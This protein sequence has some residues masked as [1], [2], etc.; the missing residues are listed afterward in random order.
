M[1]KTY[2]LEQLG[3]ANCAQKM[4]DEIE[5]IDGVQSAKVNFMLRKLTVVADT[6]PSKDLLQNIITTIEPDCRIVS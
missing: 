1:K 4:Q 6:Q 5:K 3:C 2:K